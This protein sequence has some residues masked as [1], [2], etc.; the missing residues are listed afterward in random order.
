MVSFENTHSFI[1]LIF[2]WRLSISLVIRSNEIVIVLIRLVVLYVQPPEWAIQLN[3]GV[4]IVSHVPIDIL[5]ALQLMLSI[6]GVDKCFSNCLFFAHFF[7]V[8]IP[9]NL[10]HFVGHF[11]VFVNAGWPFGESGFFSRLVLNRNVHVIDMGFGAWQKALL[12]HRWHFDRVWN[13]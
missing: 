11:R 13:Y 7:I 8:V 5:L 10:F 4:H 12:I 9:T 1:L 6:L 2:L 3:F